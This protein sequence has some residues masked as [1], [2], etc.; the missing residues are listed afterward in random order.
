MSCHLVLGLALHYVFTISKEFLV[1][2]DDYD[3]T[4]HSFFTFTSTLPIVSV[5]FSSLFIYHTI[6]PLLS[7][8]FIN[9]FSFLFLNLFTIFINA[10]HEHKHKHKHSNPCTQISQPTSNMTHI[11]GHGHAHAHDKGTLLNSTLLG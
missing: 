6:E 10:H 2:N 1:D 5:L 3:Q 11:Y 4:L 8:I 9:S 7:F